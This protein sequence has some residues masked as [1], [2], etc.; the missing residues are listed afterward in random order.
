MCMQIMLVGIVNENIV[1]YP[2]ATE[3]VFSSHLLLF[4]YQRITEIV[5]GFKKPFLIEIDAVL[6]Q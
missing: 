1:G 2:K 4:R 3:C 6:M 5:A